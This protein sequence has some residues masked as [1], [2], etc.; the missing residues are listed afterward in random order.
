MTPRNESTPITPD[1]TL[2]ELAVC[3]PGASR[4]FHRYGLDFCCHGRVA[5]QDACESAGLDVEVLL[6]ELEAERQSSEPAEELRGRG[7]KEL[8]AHILATYH[9]PLRE[10]LPR[11]I[12]MADKVER[13]HGDKPTC[14]LGLAAHLRRMFVE[15]DLH[16][17]KEER[18]LFPML[19]AGYGR[20]AQMPVS[21]MEAEHKDHAKQLEELRRLTDQYRAPEGACGTWRAL[22]LGC[23][24]LQRDLMD[25]IH[26]E[27]NIL[28]P[29]SLT[30]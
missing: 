17:Q 2:A 8:I 13:V 18:M 24:A 19:E 16:M 21:V 27:N 6:G 30:A 11:L 25:H 29:Q 5:L 23:E 26:L 15:L 7:A 10:E 22:F 3:E 12:H 28:F 4:V 1:Q 14:P 20:R 9:E